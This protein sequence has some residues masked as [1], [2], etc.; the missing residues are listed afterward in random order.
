MH[1]NLTAN[2]KSYRLYTQQSSELDGVSH[3]V[4]I[5]RGDTFE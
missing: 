2:L 4:T 1:V 3:R 5:Y